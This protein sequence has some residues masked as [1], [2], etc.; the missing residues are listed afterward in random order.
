MPDHSASQ[1]AQAFEDRVNQKIAEG[2][3]RGLKAIV[4]R[5]NE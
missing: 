4:D 1:D 5:L 3:R 2:L